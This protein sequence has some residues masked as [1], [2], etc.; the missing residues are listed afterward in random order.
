[1]TTR[2]VN[3]ALVGY[4]ADPP[5]AGNEFATKADLS[6]VGSGTV[7]IVTATAPLAV[8][9]TPTT[10]PNVT[11]ATQSANQVLAGPTTGSAAAPGFR[12]LVAADIP[13][14]P[15]SGAA[16][17]DLTGTYP[18]PT[19]TTSGVSAATYTNAT[20]TFDAKGR[21]TSA[22]SG[23]APVTAVSVSTPI[24]STGGLTP[25]IGHATS[26]VAASTY[27]A[28]ATVPVL[29]VNATGHLTS[30]TDTPIAIA[31]SQ[32]TSGQIAT[33]RGGTNAD[34]S[35]S[36]GYAYLTAGAWAFGSDMLYTS[37]TS[38]SP[39]TLGAT[40]NQFAVVNTL[41][42]AFSITLPAA[43]SGQ[44]IVISDGTNSAASNASGYIVKIVAN[45]SETFGVKG[46]AATALYLSEDGGSVVLVGIAGTGW[47]AV[48][49]RGYGVDPRSVGSGLLLWLDAR[50][51]LT[52]ASQRNVSG[53]ADFSGNGNNA[54][55][56]TAASQPALARLGA[57]PALEFRG[58]HKI[59][60]GN[61]SLSSTTF[62]GVLLAGGVADP[63]TL[64]TANYEA[65]LEWGT[66]AASGFRWWLLVGTT[67]N[68]WTVNDMAIEGGG[69]T[70][71]PN[72]HV[73]GKIT[74]GTS[75]LFPYQLGIAIPH[76]I[77]TVLTSTASASNLW[78]DGL[79]I[80][81]ETRTD[82]NVPSISSKAIT[83]GADGTTGG[84]TNF[85]YGYMASVILFT[86]ELSAANRALLETDLLRQAS[87]N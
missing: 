42:A 5:G 52:L 73:S 21:A 33:A 75:A 20:V 81:Q 11:F 49:G 15:P 59:A 2:N 13:A 54:A 36:T 79:P 40:R 60:T 29:A 56:G 61:L 39:P 63:A 27:G 70:G 85:L 10:T 8:T 77:S 58:A 12:A 80:R 18:N 78:M 34:S 44:I 65:L 84:G 55:Q 38:A 66:L 72:P 62:S 16:G 69:N 25:T 30:V 83:L 1:M 47:R 46:G 74:P 50:R 19:L 87:G 68:F 26:G 14:V 3:A 22:A 57:L 64:G 35:A 23:T 71:S 43:V 31:A 41:G 9:S 51:G 45:G 48:S 32:V 53:W 4:S 24:T 67:V 17:G 7:T 76:A 37:V 28:A 6:G 82:A 86:T